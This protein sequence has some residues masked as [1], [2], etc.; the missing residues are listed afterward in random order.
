MLDL[1]CGAGRTTIGL[2][3]L[4]YDVTAIDLSEPLLRHARS[5]HPALDFRLMDA[6]ALSFPDASFDAALFSYNGL[7]DIAPTS[8]RE[9]CLSEVHRILRP[10]GVFVL[11]G[12]NAIGHFFSGGY[13]YLRGYINAVKMIARQRSNPLLRH[14]YFRY[15]SPGGQQV[16]FSAPPSRTIAQLQHVGFDVVDVRGATGERRPSR[17]RMRQAH[18]YFVARKPAA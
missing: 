14:W 6:T 11:S 16:L 17:V 18:V 10:Q 13:F 12:H 2:A 9:R 3:R 4:G 7:D 1:G 15:D 5:R 8:A